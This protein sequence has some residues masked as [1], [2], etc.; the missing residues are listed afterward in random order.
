MILITDLFLKDIEDFKRD[1][2]LF[3]DGGIEQFKSFGSKMG[4]YG[5]GP[6]N[7]YMVRPRIPGGVISIG[8]LRAISAISE[9]YPGMQI[10][11]TTRQDIQLHSLELD[12]LG[13]VLE[14]LAKSGLTTRGAGGD[15]TRNITCSPLSGVAVNEAFD[16]TPYMEK[17]T[18]HLMSVPGAFSLP[19]KFKVSFSNNGEDTANA[20]IAD[21]GFIAKKVDGREGFEVYVAG[22]L[23]GGARKSLKIEDFIEASEVLYYAEAA[24]E[25][26]KNEGDRT[27]RHKA[28]LRFVL[29]RLGEEQFV[30][31]F[32]RQLEKLR[33]EK[34][35]TLDL[36]PVGTG[37]ATV[38]KWNYM[39][40]DKHRRVVVPQKQK[41][42]YSLYIHPYDG[43]LLPDKLDDILDFIEELDYDITIRLSMSQGLFV[44]NLKK[45][46]LNK[47]IKI[48]AGM[49]STVDLFNSVSCVGPTVCNP[50]ICNSQGLLADIRKTFADSGSRLQGELP[51]VHISGC[52]NSCAQHQVAEIGFSGRAKKTKDGLIP[53]YSLSIGGKLGQGQTSFGEVYGDIPAK[54]VSSFLLELAGLK[55]ITNH[56]SFGEFVR[57]EDHSIRELV[58]RYS[59]LEGIAEAPGI[60]RD[61]GSDSL[62]SVGKK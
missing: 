28:R 31:L 18:N 1:V 20:T 10:R 15:S 4:I 32:N 34:Q 14:D 27:N 53:A 47:L 42:R 38:T 16:V 30:E 41:S 37:Q 17:T 48:A 22:G 57:A 21:I 52:P 7:T 29:N 44:R 12:D 5:E 54:R 8:Q 36:D 9:K 59:A 50:G 3:K 33:K 60:Y 11:L 24:M 2:Q 62:F 26:F 25:V 49:I 56:K 45:K 51:L 43:R 39:V 55:S 6:K 40:A 35:L 46:D 61:F 13:N 19:R 23:G 58:S